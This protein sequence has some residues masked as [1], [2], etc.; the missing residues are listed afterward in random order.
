MIYSDFEL[1]IPHTGIM[2]RDFVLVPFIEI[3]PD[4]IMPEKEIKI[5]QIDM[6]KIEKNIISRTDHKL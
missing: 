2:N 1:N 5:S 6:D 4:F 3:A